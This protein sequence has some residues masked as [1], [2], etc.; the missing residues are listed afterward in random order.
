MAL[1]QLAANENHLISGERI[2]PPLQRS[3]SLLRRLADHL[4]GRYLRPSGL[5]LLVLV[6]GEVLEAHVAETSGRGG[7]LL[8][9][10]RLLEARR[11]RLVG[12][13]EGRQHVGDVTVVLV[14]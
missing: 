3:E 5:P 12:C 8:A 11:F 2:A 6:A 14:D 13:L 1:C 10:G 4:E 9:L 7:A